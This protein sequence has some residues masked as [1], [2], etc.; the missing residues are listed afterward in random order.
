MLFQT[1]AL[2]RGSSR[3]IFYQGVANFR[4]CAVLQ[5][6]TKS[7]LA[8]LR[9]KTGYSLSI[10]KK[11]LSENGNDL[12]LAE[13][14]L[15]EQAQAQGWAKAQKLQGR[16]TSQGL[17]GLRVQQD[18]A[19]LIE[20]N[21]ETDFVARNKKFISILDS[22]ANASLTAASPDNLDNLHKLDIDSSGV[23][24][25]ATAE[26]STIADLIALN[27]GQ[28]GENMAV[29][30]STLFFAKPGSGV[31]LAGLTHPNVEGSRD[32]LMSG[33]YATLM[34]YTLSGEGKLP[35]GYTEEKLANQICQHIIGMAPTSVR[36]EEDQENSLLHQPFLLDED[37]KV[38][39]L[40]E[41]TGLTILDFVRREVG[42]SE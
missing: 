25:L 28:I 42:R 27:I 11:A 36:N 9:K 40:T 5:G 14:W 1:S 34:A 16:N 17:L 23:G 13:A 10:C 35:E 24:L 7:D 33:R 32:K 26:G 30:R 18:V 31:K 41:S 19:A 20:L 22:V 6:S 15:K 29:G 39:E 37:I 2:C 21:C 12:K 38:E 8:A 3:G 4:I